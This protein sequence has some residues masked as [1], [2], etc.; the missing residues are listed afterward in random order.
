MLIMHIAIIIQIGVR[1]VYSTKVYA[2]KTELIMTRNWK[3]ILAWI[4]FKGSDKQ[5]KMQRK[6]R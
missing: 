1:L 6:I 4:K 5:W 3:N 2:Q